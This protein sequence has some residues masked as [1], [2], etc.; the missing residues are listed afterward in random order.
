MSLQELH[1]RALEDQ[2]VNLTRDCH[3]LMSL[4]NTDGN[5][6]WDSWPQG[7]KIKEDLERSK[8]FFDAMNR[9]R[10]QSDRRENARRETVLKVAEEIKRREAEKKA[11][12]HRKYNDPFADGFQS[13][14]DALQTFRLF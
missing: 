4:L 11:R 12:E 10:E 6:D 14:F 5:I 2:V 9:R 7:Q 3:Y 13:I 8:D 1:I